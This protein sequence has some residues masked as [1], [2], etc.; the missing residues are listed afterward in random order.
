MLIMV[1]FQMIFIHRAH[2]HTEYKESAISKNL[3]QK[4]SENTQ[5]SSTERF[6]RHFYMSNTVIH[7]VA[8]TSTQVR[9][10]TR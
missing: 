10:L 5:T 9:M 4:H 6:L 1:S 8:G 3:S 2:R 7:R